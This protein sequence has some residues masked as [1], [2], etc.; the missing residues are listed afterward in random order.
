MYK[1]ILLFA[2]FGCSFL[3]YSQA[4]QVNFQG[5]K[6]QGMGLAG[7]ALSNDASSLFFNP[8]GVAFVEKKEVSLGFTPVFANTLFVDSSSGNGYR[9]NSPLGTPFTLYALFNTKK[10]E[11]LKFGLAV[12]TPFGSTVQ[13]EENWLGRFALTRL[14]LKS[15]F[16]QPTFSYK[17]SEKLGV[18]AGFIYATGNV[19]LQKDLPVQFS[20]GDFSSAELAGKA[21]GFGFNAGINYK[22]SEKLAFGITYRSQVNMNVE[23]GEATFTVPTGLAPNFP[24]GKFTSSLPLP[25]VATL[26]TVYSFSEKLSAVL[27]I[28]YVGWKAYDTLAFD[29]ETNTSS[30][31]DT[32][33]VRNYKNIVAFRGGVS[34]EL[35]KTT[36]LRVGTGFGLTPVKTGYATPE[37]PDNNRFY[38]TLGYGA[39]IGDQFSIDFSFYATRIQRADRN[40]ETNLNGTFTTLALAAGF[41]I[42]Y[43]F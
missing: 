19:N 23:E 35:N 2:A 29:Y 12:Y 17:I 41:G 14:E 21:K 31:S 24:N 42:N 9:T 34:Y 30:L 16:I 6:Q 40:L 1:I 4:F 38:G 3:S 43:K 28:N 37:T 13:Y 18:G 10:I 8:G 7:T 33:S 39:K 5:Q 27:D 22:A 26:G 36:E 25:K 15:I 11:N 20:N 32:K